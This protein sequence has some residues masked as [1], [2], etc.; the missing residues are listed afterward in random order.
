M[1]SNNLTTQENKAEHLP[2]QIR[3]FYDYFQ[4]WEVWL[5]RYKQKGNPHLE[6]IKNFEEFMLA[7][8]RF[9]N[10]D[11]QC[12]AYA[13]L[14]PYVTWRNNDN[15]TYL[16]NLFFDIDGSNEEFLEIKAHVEELGLKWKFD[17]NSGRGKYLI[18]PVTPTAIDDSNRTEIY[19]LTASVIDYF[20]EKFKALDVRCKDVSRISRVWGSIH[21]KNVV[22]HK[23]EPLQC[24][25]MHEQVVTTEEMSKNLEIAQGIAA[26]RKSQ[27]KLFNDSTVGE[28]YA[29]DA[30]LT[31]PLLPTQ[32]KGESSTGFNDRLGKN[33]AIYAYRM[34]GRPGLELVRKCY[35]IRDKNPKEADG[36]FKKTEAN[37]D[38]KLNCYEIK[39]YLEENYTDMFD[40][41]CKRCLREKR[42]R[43][44]YT[45]EPGNISGLKEKYK[46]RLKFFITNREKFDGLV[47]PSEQGDTKNLFVVASIYPRG[48]K[49]KNRTK[50]FQQVV[51]MDDIENIGS[52]FEMFYIG[53]PL[54]N[55]SRDV[56]R[57]E[58]AGFYRYEMREGDRK[59][60]LLSEKKIEYG[61]NIITGMI[62]EVNGKCTIAEGLALRNTQQLV[63]SYDAQSKLKSL[64]N[65]EELFKLVDFTEQDL[66][67][68][69]YTKIEGG[70]TVVF[71]QPKFVNIMVLAWLLSGKKNYPVHINI[72]GSP[73]CGKTEL[74]ERISE[75]L[76]E[77]IMDCGGS[78]IKYLIPSFHGSVPEIGALFKSRRVC[79]LDEMIN[80]LART[81]KKSE[82]ASEVFIT[83]NN[84]LEHK[85][86]HEFGSG[87]G[88]IKMSMRSKV[89]SVNNPI[90]GKTIEETFKI[91]PQAYMDRFLPVRFSHNYG[92]YVASNKHIITPEHQPIKKYVL[93]SIMDYLNSF[94]IDYDKVLYENVIKEIAPTIPSEL[95]FFFS[96]RTSSHHLPL[97]LDGIVKLRCLLEKDSTW[98][99]KPCDF[100]RL[101]DWL[102][103]WVSWWWDE[104]LPEGKNVGKFLNSEQ[105][106]IIELVGKS[107]LRESLNKKLEE[108]NIERKYNLKF[109][110]DNKILGSDSNS[111]FPLVDI[112]KQELDL[113]DLEV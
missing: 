107:I 49:N 31:R 1:P 111:V 54:P 66:I 16:K 77:P 29:C 61:E 97:M 34:Y 38:F 26:E 53:E 92:L 81:G 78:T 42:N 89:I 8:K 96:S 80:M 5:M 39:H 62:V 99:A 63:F 10:D 91:L 36:W 67:D 90:T 59:Y 64:N 22:E 21:Y 3:A 74:L 102:R 7:I 18:I 100:A 14:N 84:I 2:E 43:I 94:T 6:R 46:S 104:K 88:T 19:N 60:I 58:K 52:N 25:L 56:F 109:L 95:S 17:V 44:I 86:N 83:A 79:L 72:I 87:K 65:D 82:D 28:C 105:A 32:E 23:G 55:S 48:G 9:N 50:T 113:S 76:D 103:D 12:C 24:R 41:R 93:Q 85:K 106:T 75:L 40:T 73:H 51:T 45:D 57:H 30:I 35:N 101:Q 33:L 70:K 15:V 98:T 110:Y 27:Y 47:N 112:K 108:R 20:N 69:I 68:S 11:E 4:P 71:R 37:P 13:G